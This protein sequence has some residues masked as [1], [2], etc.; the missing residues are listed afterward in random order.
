MKRN[1]ELIRYRRFGENLLLLELLN[2][3]NVMGRNSPGPVE[4]A[5]HRSGRPGAYNRVLT[6]MVYSPGVT[7]SFTAKPF[8]GALVVYLSSVASSF[9]T[10]A[11]ILMVGGL[12]LA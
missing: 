4:K 12:S 10:G 8:K 5:A 7:P 9:V 6:F 11:I 2:V 1:I 3:V